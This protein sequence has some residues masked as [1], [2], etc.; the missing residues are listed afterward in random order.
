MQIKVSFSGVAF[1]FD[2]LWAGGMK[3]ILLPSPRE[4]E[5]EAMWMGGQP[6]STWQFKLDTQQ[7]VSFT[8]DR[9][10]YLHVSHLSPASP[11]PRPH[12]SES[13]PPRFVP[14]IL[15]MMVSI[16]ALS[17]DLHFLDYL[18]G[19]AFKIWT[20][21]LPRPV[22]RCTRVWPGAEASQFT[23]NAACVI[24]NQ[25]HDV[26]KKFGSKLWCL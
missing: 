20:L 11:G 25:S 22:R 26:I 12:F 15:A 1:R 6:F 7:T 24:P 18:F 9:I 8:A 2:P 23:S 21:I 14:F 13:H 4:E 17:R 5:R 3:D 10:F 16:K 19:F